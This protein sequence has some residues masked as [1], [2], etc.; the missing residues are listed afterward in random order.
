MGI[1]SLIYSLLI[2]LSL[3][4]TELDHNRALFLFILFTFAFGGIAGDLLKELI[5]RARPV[6]ELSGKIRVTDLS[7]T[8]SF[9]SGHA[10]KSMALALPFV[11]VASNKDVL[12]KVIK[13]LV[14]I[15]A[16]LVCYSRIALQKH[17]FSDVLAGIA[18]ALLFLIVA[19]WIVNRVYARRKIDEKSLSGLNKRLGFIFIALAV[20][21]SII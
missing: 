1:I 6:V 2:F 16:L 12:T 20:I 7:D 10:T 4:N 21:V 18:T 8:S 14:L 17:F 3:K 19:Y 13:V 11:I 9:P 15:S 5:G